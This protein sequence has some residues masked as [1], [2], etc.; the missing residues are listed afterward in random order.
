MSQQARQKFSCHWCG[1]VVNQ[2]KVH[3]KRCRLQRASRR[4]VTFEAYEREAIDKRNKLISNLIVYTH[5]IEV[6]NSVEDG[7]Q[8]LR[9]ILDYLVTIGHVVAPQ[10]MLQDS[11]VGGSQNLPVATSSQAANSTISL[12]DEDNAESTPTDQ[13]NSTILVNED[14]VHEHDHEHEHQVHENPELQSLFNELF[15]ESQDVHEQESEPPQNPQQ[16]SQDIQLISIKR[17]RPAE[18]RQYAVGSIQSQ[19]ISKG[20]Y[21][22]LNEQNSVVLEPFHTKLIQDQVDGKQVQRQVRLCSQYL[23]FCLSLRSNDQS[24]RLISKLDVIECFSENNLNTYFQRLNEINGIKPETFKVRQKA[25][26]AFLDHLSNGTNAYD[27]VGLKLAVAHMMISA[28]LQTTMEKIDEWRTRRRILLADSFGNEKLGDIW[29]IFESQMTKTRLKR[30]MRQLERNPGAESPSRFLTRYCI[31]VLIL[32]YGHRPEDAQNLKIGDWLLRQTNRNGVSTFFVQRNKN[33]KHNKKMQEFVL[34][35]EDANIMEFYYKHCRCE[36][37]PP[38]GSTPDIWD[39]LP[40]FINLKTEQ[41]LT[42]AGKIVHLFQTIVKSGTQYTSNYV[43]KV[44]ETQAEE[45]FANNASMKLDIQILLGHKDFKV[46]REHYVVLTR[47]R[48]TAVMHGLLVLASQTS[49]QNLDEV[50]VGTGNI[51]GAVQT[52]GEPVAEVNPEDGNPVSNFEQYLKSIESTTIPHNYEFSDHELMQFC[53]TQQWPFLEQRDFGD[54]GRGV[55]VTRDFTKGQI[56]C[57][58]HG[59]LM[60]EDEMERHLDIL[61]QQKKNSQLPEQQRRDASQEQHEIGIY[62]FDFKFKAIWRTIDATAE[63]NS[64]GRLFNHTPHR[65]CSNVEPHI[66]VLMGADGEEKPLVRYQDLGRVTQS[67]KLGNFP[68]VLQ[69]A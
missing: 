8:R 43:R 26:L 64:F 9:A 59:N 34:L 5:Q 56:V 12:D 58:Y 62:R 31:S 25:L 14:V 67:Y 29:K 66:K 57:D 36:V 2:L 52:E 32:K 24:T 7:S 53:E 49:V 44:I 40:F 17:R 45:M 3:W 51:D 11:G 38:A 46:K 68:D 10:N 50:D 35:R 42:H 18:T 27:N 20:L 47:D 21:A 54:R 19:M 69:S 6:I 41:S 39:E 65:R 4:S 22:E 63:D 13:A 30:A 61:S 28:K 15:D 33:N 16:Q 37:P 48:L 60:D 23:Q 1:D 55:V